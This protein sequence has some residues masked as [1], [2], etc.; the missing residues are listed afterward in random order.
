MRRYIA[1]RASLLFSNIDDGI[2]T[3]LGNLI[4]VSGAPALGS[5]RAYELQ[6]SPTGTNTVTAELYGYFGSLHLFGFANATGGGFLD[7]GIDIT[8]TPPASVPE[9]ASIALLLSGLLGLGVMRKLRS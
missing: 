3:N 5:L 2:T 6:D 1:P 9:P 7:A 4:R 8:P